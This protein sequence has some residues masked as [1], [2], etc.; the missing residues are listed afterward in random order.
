MILH[1]TYGRCFFAAR[2]I[3]R[4]KIPNRKNER[5]RKL[6]VNILCK[7]HKDQ[8]YQIDISNEM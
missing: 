5:K 6:S 3:I 4:T 8:A 2:K 1:Q 7:I